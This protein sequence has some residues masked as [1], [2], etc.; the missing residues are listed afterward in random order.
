ML[1]PYI[2]C[3]IKTNILLFHLDQVGK[4][5]SI[6][7]TETFPFLWVVCAFCTSQIK[8]LPNHQYLCG[9][10]VHSMNENASVVHSLFLFE[11]SVFTFIIIKS[12]TELS[13]SFSNIWS[14]I[15]NFASQKVKDFFW[16]TVKGSTLNFKCFQT[17]FCCK[18]LSC[19]YMVTHL[20][21]TFPHGSEPPAFS[22]FGN[23]ALTR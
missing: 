20:T 17:C 23:A 4:I 16:V 6:C 9:N 19:D 2:M 10:L 14:V 18:S 11:R 22:I 21:S 7:V 15:K 1:K 3:L 5:F 12:K 13:F 8:W